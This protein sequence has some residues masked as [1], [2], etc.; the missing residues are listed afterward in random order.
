MGRGSELLISTLDLADKLP[1]ELQQGTKRAAQLSRVA[2]RY[3]YFGSPETAERRLGSPDLMV[4]EQAFQQV[5]LAADRS[6]PG[7]SQQFTPKG[8]AA[9]GLGCF[10]QELYAL[11][12]SIIAL[13]G[14]FIN[15][16]GQLRDG[17]IVQ[18][19]LQSLLLVSPTMHGDQQVPMQS[20][21]ATLA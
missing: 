9:Q 16:L 4:L 17:S 6:P 11:L 12:G 3:S 7:L 20:N 8:D 2:L 10:P 1:A 15:L 19:S 18:C 21:N 13:H 14:E 5:W